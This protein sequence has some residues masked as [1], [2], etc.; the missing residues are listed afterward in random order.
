VLDLY[1]GSGAVGLEAVSRGA[2][3]A[4]LVESEAAALR[5]TVARVGA[6]GEEVR[7]IE[8][9]AA[10]AIDDLIREGEGFDIVF[11]DP[12]YDLSPKDAG[13]GRV[14][15]LMT[16]EGI[17]VFQRDGTTE[18]PPEVAGLRLLRHREYGRNVFYFFGML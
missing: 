2:S 17:F 11:A 14:A 4:V 3:R 1:A 16:P 15:R 10:A 12:P 8:R 13:V 5:R 18:A 7:V 9:G 6:S